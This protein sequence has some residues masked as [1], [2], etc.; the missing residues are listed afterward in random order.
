MSR[1]HS[2][3]EDVKESSIQ[4]DIMK[5]LCL[6]KDVAWAMVVTTGQFRVKGGYIYT[7]HY[8]TEDMIRK[9]G[10]SDIIGQLKDGRFFSIETKRP[11]EKPSPEQY[12]FMGHVLAN[13][14]VAGWASNVEEA[15]KILE[16]K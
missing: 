9:T 5:M 11:G 2:K 16:E 7:G 6:H 15:L 13:K 8:A 12:E 10:M 4:Q 1:L 14:G 3:K